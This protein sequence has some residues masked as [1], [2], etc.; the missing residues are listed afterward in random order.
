MSHLHNQ[1]SQGVAQGLQLNI[2]LKQTLKALIS[3]FR[4]ILDIVINLR[5][6]NEFG[7]HMDQLSRDDVFVEGINNLATT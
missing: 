5:R 7:H 3:F 6:D 4:V 2:Q 1:S